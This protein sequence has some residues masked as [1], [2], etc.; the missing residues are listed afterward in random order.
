MAIFQREGN[1]MGIYRGDEEDFIIFDS[2]YIRLQ[3]D[4]DDG[5]RSYLESPQV[6]DGNPP[7]YVTKFYT[8]IAVVTAIWSDD[9]EEIDKEYF[10]DFLR[11]IGDDGYL[12][13]QAG[14]NY[15]DEYYPYAYVSWHPRETV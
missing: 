8:P 3:T 1:L 14:T 2:F 11:V 5:Y 12:W 9:W 6:I 7:D 10:Y 4:P 15:D 13:C